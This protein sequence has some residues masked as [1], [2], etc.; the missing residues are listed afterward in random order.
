LNETKVTYCPNCGN[1]LDT[2]DQFC[3]S[4]GKPLTTNP[5]QE[6]ELLSFGP[7]GVS[8]C[9]KRPGFFTLT[10]QNDT[11]IILTNKRI[12]GLSSFSGKPRFEANYSTINVKEITNYA[13]FK[14]L[15]LQYQDDQKTKEVSIMG[16]PS[17][18]SNITHA[19]ELIAEK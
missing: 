1:K 15:Y 18:Y 2:T 4:C 16:N 8:V 11:K 12:Y 3:S 17:N 14:V 9:F 6:R 19:Y 5:E 13:L 7:M 10:Q